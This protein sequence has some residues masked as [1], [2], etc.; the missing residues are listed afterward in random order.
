MGKLKTIARRTFLIGSAGIVGG[1]VFGYWKYKTPYDN[2][3]KA[4]LGEGAAALTPYVKIDEGGV[5]IITPRAEM[6]QGV[7]TTLAA[8]VAEELDVAFEAIKV[9]HGPASSAYFNEA[10][11]ADGLP[12]APTDRGWLAETARASVAIP[13]KLLGMQTTGGSST[14]P[15][16]YEKM[17]KAGAAARLV[18]IEAAAQKLGVDVSS[19]KTKDGAVIT[20]TG[21]R[22]SYESLA[23]A[24][25]GIEPPTDPP[26][27]PQSEWRYLGKSMPRVDVVA[28]ST[29]TAEYSIDVRLPEMLYATVKMNPRLGGAMTAYDDSVAREMRGYIKTIDI[30]GG[31][32]VI[33][34]NTWRAFEAAKAVECTWAD[35]PYPPSTKAI[36]D[37][38]ETS[39]DEGHRDNRFTDLG[40]IDAALDGAVPVQAEYRVPILAHATMEPMNAVAWLRDGKLDIW[41]GNQFPTKAKADG[42]AIAGIDAEQVAVHTP[43]LGGGFGRKTELDFIQYAVQVAK[44]TEGK[45]VKVTWSREE[46]MCHDLYRPPAIA[47]FRGAVENGMPTAYD[48]KI[49]SP[50]IVESVSGRMGLPTVGPDKLIVDGAY[51]QPYAIPNYRITGYRSPPSIPISFWRSVGASYNG[52]F[53]ESF[54]DELAHAAETD[55]LEMRLKLINHD[56]SRKVLEAVGEMSDWGSPLASGKGRGVAFTLSFNVPTAEVIEVSM[57][58]DGLKVDKAWIAADVGTAL[59]PGIL[60]AQLSSGLIYGLTAAIQGEITLEDGEVQQ[61]N[62]HDYDGLR[63]NQTPEIAVRILENGDRITGI[64]EPG[65][66]PAP[67]ALANA[68]FAA[69]GQRIRELPLNKHI[70][71]V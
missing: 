29:G 69:T 19:L 30:G 35:A 10:I 9:E 6:G 26:L 50:S 2:P 23:V 56:V 28:K 70:D 52:F 49:A 51:G 21:E 1:V 66:P 57:T 3:L 47:R 7:H 37:A 48:G 34:D 12:F 55:P 25:A 36:F 64:G 33:A 40:D 43:Y 20:P 62:F 58:E 17:R 16:G 15:D 60:E 27:K 22:H 68:I 18:L 24:A 14:T 61:T 41:A 44:H 38:I 59:D 54:M 45:P 39:F 32:A 5:T 67:A 53:H 46:D 4:G 65:T 31:V 8:M 42:A 11:M 71:F 63:I 13:A